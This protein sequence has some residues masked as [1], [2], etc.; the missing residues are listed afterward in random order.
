M[1]KSAGRMKGISRIDQPDKKNHGWFARV[2]FKGE[3][4]S[5]WFADRQYGGVPR[6]LDAAREWVIH[7]HQEM[8]KP[9]TGRRVVSVSLSSTQVVGV[10]KDRSGG[11]LVCWSPVEGEHRREYVPAQDGLDEAVKLRRRLA[12]KMYEADTLSP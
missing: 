2:T 9:L 11:F 6:A 5:K 7:T 3:R 1:A 10:S 12:K 8:G 4:R